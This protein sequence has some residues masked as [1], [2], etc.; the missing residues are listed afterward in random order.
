VTSVETRPREYQAFSWVL[1]LEYDD[2]VKPSE[3]QK[4]HKLSPDLPYYDTKPPSGVAVAKIE[5]VQVN[6]FLTPTLDAL[7]RKSVSPDVLDHNR[8]G[9]H[10]SEML[11]SADDT[12]EQTWSPLL[13]DHPDPDD[14]EC[15]DPHSYLE[16]G[17]DYD[18]PSSIGM[19]DSQDPDF[20]APQQRCSYPTPPS[21]QESLGRTRNESVV[22][23][24][25]LQ[26][27]PISTVDMLQVMEAGLK[28]ATLKSPIRKVKSATLSSNESLKPL[29]SI[30]PALWVPEY[31][32]S[33][34]SRAVLIPTISHAIANVSLRAST[35]MGLNEKVRQ[36]A[37]QQSRKDDQTAPGDV[38]IRASELQDAASVQI[39][40]GMTSTLSSS[41]T[42][43]KMQPFSD[44][45]KPYDHTG[46]YESMEDMLDG[47]AID[48]ESCRSCDESDFEDLDDTPS[49][50]GE[51]FAG[52]IDELSELESM[53]SGWIG[54]SEDCLTDHW[55]SDDILLDASEPD[56]LGEAFESRSELFCEIVEF[57]DVDEG[58][59]IVGS[60]VKSLVPTH[61]S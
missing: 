16:A 59:G 48:Q 50:S 45:A 12:L 43:K 14:I 56:L 46:A 6:M 5:L 10:D 28:C 24:A 27:R 41:A 26:F 17:R 32:R 49:E 1:S 57:R 35:S 37:R 33:T 51:E 55:D 40:Q 4:L 15:H 53:F 19:Q 38:R 34:A 47:A 9:G 11:F 54:G 18:I 61:C 29:S 39:W 44:V 3:K 52:E 36:L 23:P 42:P 60:G 13:F 21:S 22:K 30:A 20:S 8:K 31:H 2:R 58:I 7:L 25:T